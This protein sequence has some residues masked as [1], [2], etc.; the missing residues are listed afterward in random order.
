MK[1][2]FMSVSLAIGILSLCKAGVP[3]L[4]VVNTSG[5]NIKSNSFSIDYSVGEAVIGSANLSTIGFL[6]LA[7]KNS[8][9]A[10]EN[11]SFSSGGMALYPNP[12]SD[13]V[14]WN[15]N[16]HEVK[17]A[18]IFAY[19][20]AKVYEENVVNQELNISNLSPGIYYVE[21]SGNSNQ[22]LK[23]FKIVKN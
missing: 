4:Q 18:T 19:S 8:L 15:D 17:K 11:S 3:D 5:G 6:Q 16:S 10:L 9:L 21:F 23:T 2:K 22:I 12:S 20:G 7:P 14:Y 13:K 1:Y